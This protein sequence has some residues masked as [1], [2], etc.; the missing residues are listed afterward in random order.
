MLL[1]IEILPKDE[2]EAKP[3]GYG[4]SAPNMHPRLPPPVGRM[5]LVRIHW[6]VAGPRYMR[7]A[8]LAHERTLA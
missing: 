8:T 7:F 1:S 5:K 4:R 3:N 2:A 6:N